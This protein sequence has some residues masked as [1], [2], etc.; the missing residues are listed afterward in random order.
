MGAKPVVDL[1]IYTIRRRSMPEFL[2]ISETLAMPVQL[3]HIGPPLAYYVTD[4][5]PQN[6]VI[7][8][9]PYESV[10]DMDARRAARNQDP[11]W[12]L[13]LAASDGLILEQETRVVRRVAFAGL[14]ELSES[15]AR[16]PLVDFRVYTIRRR[17]MPEFLRISE[18]LAM[19]VQLRHIGPPLA[20][21]V[22][23]IGPQNQVIHLWSYD[24]LAD[25]EARRAA[26]NRDPEWETYLNA[27][28]GLIL[29]QETRA[30]RR[31]PFSSLKAY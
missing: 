22:T 8:L 14:T 15:V 3:R 7:H 10:A 18:T 16:K 9:W 31:V 1:R 11:E 2:R 17:G 27:S 20:Y 4:I 28:E 12:Q 26:R 29:E 5:G 25:M 6:Q 13:Y 21:Y 24:S 19:P 23:E 30:V